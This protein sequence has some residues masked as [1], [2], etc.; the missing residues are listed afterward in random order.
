MENKE[1]HRHTWDVQ[2]LTMAQG[3]KPLIPLNE[4]GV[5]QEPGCFPCHSPLPKLETLQEGA[6]AFFI[7]GGGPSEP[8]HMLSSLPP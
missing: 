7:S 4:K 6:F 8:F 5:K 1:L 2:F 3:K